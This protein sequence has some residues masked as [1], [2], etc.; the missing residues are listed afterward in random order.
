VMNPATSKPIGQL[1]HVS[2]GDLDKALAAADKGFKQWR[3]TSAYERGK[4]LRK[5]AD[6]VRA[7]TDEIATVLTMEEG[8]VLM[9]AKLEVASAASEWS[10]AAGRGACG[11]LIPACAA[12][13]RNLVSQEPI[14]VVAGFSP[15][16]FPVTQA[17]RKV[18]AA[19][20]AGCA[21]IIKCPEE[22]PGSPIG[23]IKCFHDAGLPAGVL[24]LVY[25]VPAGISEDLLP[26]PVI[27][28]I[29]FTGSG[30]VRKAPHT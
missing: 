26:P 7:R 25:G 30:P 14:G 1:G 5:A 23:L 29:S 19:L 27:R 11:R 17:V 21:I 4:I 16:N 8:K 24:H 6:L 10:A 28:Q 9:E 2:R 15:W 13:V 12:G 3:K 18:A 20:A 22:T